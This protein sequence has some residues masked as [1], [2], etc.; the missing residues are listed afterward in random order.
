MIS[1]GSVISIRAVSTNRSAHRLVGELIFNYR[2]FIAGHCPA[3]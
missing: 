3:K 1:L 2:D